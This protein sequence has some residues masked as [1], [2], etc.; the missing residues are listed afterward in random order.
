MASREY[1]N[2]LKQLNVWVAIRVAKSLE[3]EQL[4]QPNSRRVQ[5]HFFFAP[6]IRRA[7]AREGALWRGARALS[8]GRHVDGGGG[9]VGSWRRREEGGNQGG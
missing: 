9:V 3:G 6:L 4:E 1:R 8:D 7:I 5:A 2:K